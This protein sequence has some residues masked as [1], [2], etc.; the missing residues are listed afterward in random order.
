MN[1]L[2][3]VTRSKQF[4]DGYNILNKKG[5]FFLEDNRVLKLPNGI[6]RVPYAFYSKHKQKWMQDDFY[7]EEKE[8]EVILLEIKILNSRKNIKKV[9]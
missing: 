5:H 9:S 1:K 6:V 2:K 8:F 7:F 3:L 4:S